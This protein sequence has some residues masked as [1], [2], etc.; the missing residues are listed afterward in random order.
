MWANSCC[1]EQRSVCGHWRRFRLHPL[2]HQVNSDF[3]L[4]VIIFS[5]V[6]FSAHIKLVYTFSKSWVYCFIGSDELDQHQ[7]NRSSW[8]TQI[9]AVY[10]LHTHSWIKHVGYW[11]R[12]VIT[13]SLITTDADPVSGPSALIGSQSAVKARL[14]SADWTLLSGCCGGQWASD[15]L[16]PAVLL[17]QSGHRASRLWF[18]MVIFSMV[19]LADFSCCPANP[20]KNIFSLQHCIN[21]LDFMPVLNHFPLCFH[22][23][24][25]S[26]GTIKHFSDWIR[27]NQGHLNTW[28]SS[29]SD[30]CVLSCSDWQMGFTEPSDTAV[31]LLF[32]EHRCYQLITFL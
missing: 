18:M 29:T 14:S 10:R 9:D 22:A 15:Q 28:L 1:V 11:R 20:T 32:L 4:S 25:A 16:L 8:N 17:D 24:A 26:A 2:I 21:P 19:L 27:R 3:L 7:Q 12:A 5:W 13:E 30:I 6:N 31:L 23:V